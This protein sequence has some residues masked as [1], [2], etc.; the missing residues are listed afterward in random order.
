[1]T[2]RWRWEG[3]DEAPRTVERVKPSMEL[4]AEGV[5]ALPHELPSFAAEDRP[6]VPSFWE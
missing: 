5:R 6:F 1:M 4:F 3:W 2:D